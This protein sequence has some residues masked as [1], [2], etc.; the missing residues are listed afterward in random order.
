MFMVPRGATGLLSPERSPLQ[1]HYAAT[2]FLSRAM[3]VDVPNE[4]DTGCDAYILHRGF[5]EHL[6]ASLGR[7]L[8][9]V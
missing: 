5:V 3:A 7:T 8:L 2:S 4:E 9:F 1:H 6:Q